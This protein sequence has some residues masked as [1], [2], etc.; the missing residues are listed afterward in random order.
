MLGDMLNCHNWGEV[1]LATGI[2]L[3]V[4]QSTATPHATQNNLEKNAPL[5]LSTSL[6]IY[7]FVC[8]FT[9]L[10]GHTQWC[11]GITPGSA[12]GN[13]SLQCLKNYVGFQR[14]NWVSH[15]QSKCLPHSTITSAPAVEKYR[16]RCFGCKRHKQILA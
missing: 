4:P 3:H 2:F 7:L 11:S 13:N 14:S 16:N 10:L 1:L 15:M 8:L 12:L 5:L 6:C 9:L